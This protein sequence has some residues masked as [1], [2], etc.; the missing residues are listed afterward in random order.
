M[1][2]KLGLQKGPYG[3]DDIAV[4]SI[5]RSEYA[6]SFGQR[7]TINTC[8]TLI[9]TSAFL[10]MVI[11]G[12]MDLPDKAKSLF[13]YVHPIERLCSQGLEAK[14]EN[15]LPNDLALRAVGNVY[16]TPLI[17]AVVLPLANSLAVWEHVEQ[18]TEGCFEK[19]IE[20]EACKRAAQFRIPC[21]RPLK[22]IKVEQE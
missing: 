9:C 4:L 15:Y 18:W 6:S 7:I 16:P 5:D 1:K 19:V 12:E 11:I 22:K 8:L 10:V 20:Q 3:P 14:L 2:L 21:P 17:G 13:R